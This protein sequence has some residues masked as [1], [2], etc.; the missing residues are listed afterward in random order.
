MEFKPD[1]SVNKA[2]RVSKVSSIPRSSAVISARPSHDSSYASLFCKKSISPVASIPLTSHIPGA[3]SYARADLLPSPKRIRSSKFAMDLEGCSK[4]RFEPSRHRETNLEMDVDVV[5]SHEIDIDPEIQAEID[6]CFAYA[7]ALRDRGIDAKVLVE[8]VDRDEIETGARDPIKVRVDRVTHPVIA[9]DI[10]EPAQEEGVVEVTYEMLGDLVQRTMP[11]TRSGASRTCEA[12][13]EQIDHRLTGAL[14]ARDA[15]RNLEPLMGNGG[16]G[17]GGNKNRG[18]GNGNGNGGGNGYNFG[19]FMPARECTYQDFLKCQPLS[20][21][22]TEGVVR[23]THWFEKME[24]VFPSSNCPEK[25]Q[26]KYA[27][28]I[29]LNSALTWWNYHKRTIG[30]EPPMP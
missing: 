4:D 25:Y 26:V 27:M 30:I 21:N 10:L 8:A 19:G 3:L 15:A 24:T 28:Y 29:F 23:L 12:V 9:D 18:N 11:Y 5:R 17:N 20:F 22:G 6:E 1:F 14:G 16:N 7:D 13:N 2:Q